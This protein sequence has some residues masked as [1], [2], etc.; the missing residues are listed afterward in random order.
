MTDIIKVGKYKF[1]IIKNIVEYR[2]EIF[3]HTYKLGG[4]Y[5]D[6]INIS[7]IYKNNKPVQ[8]K[9]PHLLYEPECAVESSLAKGSGTEIMIK[10]AIRYAYKDV[11]SITKFEFDD[12][13]H[14]DCV[15]KD[16]TKSPP[17][18]P[19]KPLNLAFLFI[20]YH[21]MTWYEARFNAKMIN[22]TKYKKYKKSLEFLTKEKPSFNTFLQI[23]KGSIDSVEKIEAL[24]NYYSGAT[25]YKEFFQAIPRNNR[26]DL[27]YGWLNTFINHYI[28]F[29]D[30]GWFID[31]NDMDTTVQTGGAFT[32]KKHK[33]F[34]YKKISSF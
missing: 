20:A 27:L 26:C 2:G 11:P 6:C 24:E 19:V 23:I 31:V 22:Q 13:S 34:S 33:I 28:V 16:L 32:R 10:A 15:D 7:Y 29:D 21:G 25:T 12:D 14:I 3:I 18:K 5:E 4:D 1:K 9:L 30:K 8:V 17:R